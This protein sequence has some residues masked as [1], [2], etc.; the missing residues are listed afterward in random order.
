[1]IIGVDVDGVLIDLETY[2]LKCGEQYFVHKYGK[3]LISPSE[4][5]IEQ[6]FGCT[7]KE[8]K[9]FWKKYIW[10]YCL[11]ESPMNNASAVISKLRARGHK[12]IIITSRVY[13]TEHTICGFVFR[14]MLKY[15]LLKN[16]IEY[17]EIVFCSDHDSSNDK[18]KVC[19]DCK[20][21][22][23]IDDKM[24]NLI[25]LVGKI[26]PLCYSAAWNR[27]AQEYN[28]FLV[29]DWNHIYEKILEYESVL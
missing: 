10:A 1:M 28:L 14:K 21:D 19:I 15:W 17:D 12:I 24:E 27:K 16:S 9:K 5:E 25:P 20:V 11:T 3:K 2:Q 4:Y 18:Y 7:K 29:N 26:I 8:Q 6:I 22:V 23:M 13:T